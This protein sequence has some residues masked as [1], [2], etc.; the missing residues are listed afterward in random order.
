MQN[1]YFLVYFEGVFVFNNNLLSYLL[2]LY[3]LEFLEASYLIF[4]AISYN[5]LAF[6]PT[7]SKF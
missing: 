3:I 7:G 5:F 2:F 1:K 4:S 6:D